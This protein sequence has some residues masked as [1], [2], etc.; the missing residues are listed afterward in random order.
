MISVS[1]LWRTLRRLHEWWRDAN[2]ASNNARL[3]ML[4]EPGTR[5]VAAGGCDRGTISRG[6]DNGKEMNPQ[7]LG[8]VVKTLDNRAALDCGSNPYSHR[9]HPARHCATSG[10]TKNPRC[11]PGTRDPLRML[12]HKRAWTYTEAECNED[13]VPEFR[14][15][16]TGLHTHDFINQLLERRSR[17]L[18][19]RGKRLKEAF[20]VL[21]HFP[22]AHDYLTQLPDHG[23]VYLLMYQQLAF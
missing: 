5:T 20:F 9:P 2:A 11:R 15:C 1:S 14:P 21:I 22:I 12:P 18:G 8:R 7:T 17:L 6:S 19:F 3:V 10:C 13:A 16:S 4:L 23:A